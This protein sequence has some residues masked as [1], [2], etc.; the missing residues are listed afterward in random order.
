MKKI[1]VASTVLASG[2]AL[3]Q[4]SNT[5]HNLTSSGTGANRST[6]TEI[7]AFCHTPHAG[8]VSTAGAPL[9][10]RKLPTG[11]SYTVYTSSTLDQ[12]GVGN[13]GQPGG[14]SLACLSCHDGTQAMDVM[15]N[16]PGSG[17]WNTN[18]ATA[19]YTWTG[20]NT[21]AA[22]SVARLGT[23]LSNDHPIGIV[24]CGGSWLGTAA[25]ATC[26][27]ADFRAPTKVT[28]TQWYVEAGSRSLNSTAK[29]KQDLTLYSRGDNT[30]R[31]ECGSCHDPH[32]TRKATN[33][34]NFMRVSQAGSGLCLTCHNK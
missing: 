21:I 30:I 25:T 32:V 26:G 19:G 14:I 8:D 27:D 4:I 12:T 23:D 20:A 11:S 2:V 10:N 24:Y 28:N 33:Q 3:G 13:A 5:P 34:T 22:T 18:G 9:W 1:V 31:V 6:G 29:D 15:I 17:G 7:C 16:Q